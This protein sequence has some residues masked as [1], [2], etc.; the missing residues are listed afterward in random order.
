M[1]F[2]LPS[3]RAVYPSTTMGI[4]LQKMC[5]CST[6]KIQITMYMTILMSTRRRNMRT[7]MRKKKKQILLF[8]DIFPILIVAIHQLPRITTTHFSANSNNVIP[9]C[10]F[11]FLRD[12]YNMLLTLHLEP[13]P[14]RPQALCA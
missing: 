3:L 2:L 6:H 1:I 4:N 14:P 12:N 5:T 13:F 7:L 9:N 11:F 10:F 8:H